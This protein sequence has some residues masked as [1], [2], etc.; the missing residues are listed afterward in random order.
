MKNLNFKLI[1]KATILAGTLDIIAAFL[2]FYFKTGKNVGIVLKYIASAILGDEAYKGGI[3]VNLL[4]LFLHYIIAFLFTL[5]FAIIYPKILKWLSQTLLIA[6]IYGIFVWI[7]MNLLIV[8]STSAAEIPFTWSAGLTNCMIL[9]AC[10]GY[11]L[12][13][14]FQKNASKTF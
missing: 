4:G 6:I 1:L 13:H 3:L 8:P 7:V 2:N 5:F 12:A 11:P 10:I 14:L 9:I